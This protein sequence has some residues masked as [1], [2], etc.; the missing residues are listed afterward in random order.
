MCFKIPTYMPNCLRGNSEQTVCYECKQFYYYNNVT[1][2]CELNEGCPKDCLKCTAKNET[3]KCECKSGF[4]WD[5]LNSQC[6]LNPSD[7][8]CLVISNYTGNPQCFECK[9]GF[10]LTQ[11]GKGC[12]DA[13]AVENCNTCVHSEVENY[14]DYC[15]VCSEGYIVNLNLTRCLKC[16]VDFC[17]TCAGPSQLSKCIECKIGY[18]LK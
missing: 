14:P 18:N 13:C 4:V 11:D 7:A 6:V 16:E 3:L 9:D 10:T 8:Q 1:A 2:S 15:K 17:K 5:F 12:E